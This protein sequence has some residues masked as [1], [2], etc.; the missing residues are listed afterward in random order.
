MMKI[1][2][3]ILILFFS[4]V[5][6]TQENKIDTKGRK[7]GLWKKYFSKS[8]IVDYIGNFEDDIPVGEF[9]Y[10]F[11]NGKTKAKM[12]FKQNGTI[13]YSTI[14]HE[15][16]LNNPLASG[17]YVNKIK[18]SVWNYWGSSGKISMIETF[19][20]GKLEGKKTI[21]Y[22]PELKTDTTVYIAQELHFKN[23]VRNGEQKEYFNNGILKSK[24]NFLNDKMEGEAFYYSPTGTIEMKENYLNGMKEGWCYLYDDKELE[25]RKVFFLNGNKLDENQTKK[26]LQKLNNKK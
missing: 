23:G 17:K 20:L 13:C 9:L 10:Y 2:V 15:D 19:K 11:K 24:I 25:V 14:Y 16:E 12:I 8:L 3:T 7:Q 4:A 21:Y 26:Y 6:L 22:V 18:D 5:S 1:H